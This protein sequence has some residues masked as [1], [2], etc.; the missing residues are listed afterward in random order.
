L[1]D[2]K[3]IK[4]FRIRGEHLHLLLDVAGM[5]LSS[6]EGRIERITNE[7]GHGGIWHPKFPEGERLLIVLSRLFAAMSCDGH[8]S[9]NGE[10]GYTE[11]N[12]SRIE[13]VEENLRE[14][15]DIRVRAYINEK[16]NHYECGLPS[17]L[18]DILKI[19]GLPAGDKTIQNPTLNP[20]FLEYFSWRA[21]CAFVEDSV[22]EDGSVM[23]GRVWWTHT[24]A[25]HPGDKIEK[26]DMIPLVGLKEI[27]FIKAHGKES[28]SNW[29]L[30]MGKLDRLR[31][32]TNLEVK[33]TATELYDIVYRN[34]SKLTELEKDV[35]EK[36]GIKVRHGPVSVYYHKKTERVTVAWI[37]HTATSDEAMKLSMIAPSNDIKKRAIMREWIRN[38]P[39]DAERIYSEL[40]R[41]NIEV[42]TWWYEE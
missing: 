37:C 9:K 39:E 23:P 18:G 40:K 4:V 27:N 15:G 16:R 25:L 12:L 2:E 33:Q 26:Y 34:P 19:M 36:L 1:T 13:L 31:E 5:P 10:V 30:P 35:V 41:L 17:I 8:I 38:N 24:C 32:S 28:T 3:G 22:P 29:R 14:L 7:T 42:H 11:E 20:E 21:L 6:L